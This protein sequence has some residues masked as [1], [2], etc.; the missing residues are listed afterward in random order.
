MHERKYQDYQDLIIINWRTNTETI[1]RKM[2]IKS[3]VFSENEI[4]INYA[5]N[6]NQKRLILSKYYY[7]IILD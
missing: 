6:G 1:K 5:K 4:T 7:K 3:I 2:D